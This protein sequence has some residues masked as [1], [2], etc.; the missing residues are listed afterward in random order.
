MTNVDDYSSEELEDAFNLV[1]DKDD[2]NGP[3]CTVVDGDADMELIGA[4]VM[5]YTKGSAQFTP[6]ADGTILVTADG[7]YLNMVE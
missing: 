6:Q 5:Y 4:A 1:A 7:Y 2:P 3:I